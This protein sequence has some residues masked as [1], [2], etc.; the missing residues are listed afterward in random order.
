MRIP[1]VVHKGRTTTIRVRLGYDVSTDTLTSE[2][3]TEL[4][5][6]SDLIATWAVSFQTTG[7]DGVLVLTLDN[8]QTEGI[9]NTNGYMD[10]K[11]V[12]NGEP[13]SVFYEPVPVAFRET[14]TQ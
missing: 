12:V 11:R 9:P 7:V 4:D 1:I 8:L 2:I 14:I 5:P 3:R 13:L 10:I 6:A